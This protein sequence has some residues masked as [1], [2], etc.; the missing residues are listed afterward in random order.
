M[1]KRNSLKL[2]DTHIQKMIKPPA[3]GR[4]EY[5]DS[6]VDN[7]CLRISASG[8]RSWCI[9]YRLGGKNRRYT[10][11]N[12]PTYS[13]AEARVEANQIKKIVA[14]G[15]D[16]VAE[17]KV[18]RAKR[19]AAMDAEKSLAADSV[20][21]MADLFITRYVQK[22]VR[23]ATAKDYQSHFKVDIIPSWGGRTVS[24]I[25]RADISSLLDTVEDRAPIQCNRVR[26]TLSKW[27]NWMVERGA[28]DV[29]PVLSTKSRTKEVLRDRVLSEEELVSIWQASSN[30]GWPFGPI[31][32][33]LLLT[34][35][36]RGEVA[37]MYWDELNLKDQTWSIQPERSG[38]KQRQVSGRSPKID[39]V[40]LSSHAVNLIKQ[41]PR[42]GGNPLVFP[43][44]S[45]NGTPVSGFSR[46]CRR[47]SEL[48][49]V[50]N[51]R[52]HDFRATV[53][54]NLSA[55]GVR[56]EVADKVLNHVDNTT[57]GRH[58][59]FYDY[60]PEKREAL[61]LWANKLISTVDSDPSFESRN[62][63]SHD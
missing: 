24:T 23:P 29:N 11:G 18:E 62:Q 27:F 20:D 44:M 6:Q 22:N 1:P 34:A 35:K 30:I 63:I 60:L 25:T 36:R 54:T 53:R 31:F 42:F 43:S 5:F 26:A 21:V 55:L 4:R 41:F 58:Y 33:L 48:S 28:L 51:W 52:I 17:R 19:A 7:L 12:Y 61:Q 14:K 40:P 59:D 37:G 47:V 46:A 49:N 2:T 50:T 16:P 13:I 32:Q 38:T 39:V 56:K 10:I 3:S 9:Y 45:K 8:N 57:D 15:D